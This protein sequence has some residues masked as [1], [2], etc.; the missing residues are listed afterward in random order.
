MENTD[1]QKYREGLISD[2]EKLLKELTED[3][4]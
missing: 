1:E 4:D 2:I 3:A